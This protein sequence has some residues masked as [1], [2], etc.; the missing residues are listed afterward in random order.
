MNSRRVAVAAPATHGRE[1]YPLC[2]LP[3]RRGCECDRRHR[4]SPAAPARAD[5]NEGASL[6]CLQDD[7]D[8]PMMSL[9]EPISPS[10]QHRMTAIKHLLR[11]NF[12]LN[13]QCKQKWYL[14]TSWPL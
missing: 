1:C 8:R 4:A 6:Q 2:R 9:R 10:I 13:F 14:L 5:H 3:R 12:A 11:K 7:V